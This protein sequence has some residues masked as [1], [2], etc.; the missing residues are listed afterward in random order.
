M[1]KSLKEDKLKYALIS[2]LFF[3]MTIMLHLVAGAFLFLAMLS[4]L[5]FYVILKGKPQKRMS[6]SF[7]L[8]FIVGIGLALLWSSWLIRPYLIGTQSSSSLLLDSSTE[9]VSTMSRFLASFLQFAQFRIGLLRSFFV[10]SF[11]RNVILIIL[12]VLGFYKFIRDFKILQ[13]T[14]NE[15]YLLSNTIVPVVLSFIPPLF[16]FFN[17]LLRSS[18]VR[19]MII[20]PQL[21]FAT[22]G[23]EWLCMVAF[24]KFSFNE[25][26]PRFNIVSKRAILMFL[27]IFLIIGISSFPKYVYYYNRENELAS[28][29]IIFDL[30]SDFTWLKENS[31]KDSV[32]LSDPWTSYYIPYFTERKVVATHQTH[33]IS[34]LISTGKRVS[35]VALA[36]NV[37][38]PLVETLIIVKKYNVSHILLNLRPFLDSEYTAYKQYIEDYYSLNTPQKF[39]NSPNF[40]KEVYYFNGVWIFEI[41]K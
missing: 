6:Y 35:D 39:Y 17:S 38:T 22:I 27:M 28:N 30:A 25:F 18:M 33:S 41:T 36:L 29:P 9:R 14:E 26:K 19:F 16:Y 24:S 32:I 31:D 1:L 37:S 5:F 10:I 20:L 2:A 21:V 8:F 7:I 12:I 15:I 3:S 13:T 40:F 4:F 34:Y 11:G 23:F